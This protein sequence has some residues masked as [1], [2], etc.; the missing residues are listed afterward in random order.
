MARKVGSNPFRIST[1]D[2]HP[3]LAARVYACYRTLSPVYQNDGA[4][5]TIQN[6]WHNY[7]DIQ[8]KE[9]DFDF[10]CANNLIDQLVDTAI[11]NIE[12]LIPKA[13]RYNRPLAN[14]HMLMEIPASGSL[15]NI[16]NRGVKILLTEPSG[17][18]EW[19]KNIVKIL[20]QK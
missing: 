14:V 13:K 4:I 7:T 9:S 8:Q 1:T 15:E 2:V 19:E 6:I 3:P 18:A 11:R 12:L 20:L 17:Y 10:I 16:L 5:T